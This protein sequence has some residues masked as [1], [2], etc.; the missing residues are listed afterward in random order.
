MIPIYLYDEEG[1]YI[2]TR[3]VDPMGPVPQ[4]SCLVAPPAIDAGRFVRWNSESWVVLEARPA[5][6]VTP[7][8]PLVK[9]AV[10]KTYLDVDGVYTDAVGQR[11]TEYKDAEMAARAFVEAGYPNGDVSTYISQF[12]QQNPTLQVQT[13]RWAADQIIARADAFAAA[14]LS[15]RN[16]RFKSQAAMRSANDVQELDAATSAWNEFIAALRGQLGLPT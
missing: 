16:Q 5:K 14:Q 12:A 1:F 10:D 2:E 7:L 15:M 6:P 13:N 8:A 11:T 3:A 4:R 9:A